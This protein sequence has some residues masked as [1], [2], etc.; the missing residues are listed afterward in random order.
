MNKEV[1]SLFDELYR[2]ISKEK[3]SSE[4]EKFEELK[5]QISVYMG[6]PNAPRG[7]S[8]MVFPLNDGTVVK[9]ALNAAG[10]AQ[11]GMEATIGSDDEVSDIVVPVM[12]KSS[13][14]DYD[15]Y[16][17]IASKRVKPLSDDVAGK[18]WNIFAGYL[19]K[20]ATSSDPINA[21]YPDQTKVDI[22]QAAAE[23]RR[24]EIEDVR[25]KQMSEP[26][27]MFKYLPDSFFESFR[28][29]L[30]RYRGARTG[31]LFKPDSWGID[32][33]SL[34]LIDYGYT[35]RISDDFYTS[36]M[37]A[38]S[39]KAKE[40]FVKRVGERM[41]NIQTTLSDNAETVRNIKTIP[42]MTT[43]ALLLKGIVTGLPKHIETFS[44]GDSL[45]P[46]TQTQAASFAKI[47][48]DNQGKIDRLIGLLPDEDL[49]NK[50]QNEIEDLLLM[51]GS[52]AK[53]KTESI[54]RSII[55]KIL[56]ESMR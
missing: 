9:L 26:S 31:D 4:E 15:G 8:R 37:F 16:L 23:K 13:I 21:Q 6:G 12:G 7:S 32:G 56:K 1:L 24:K 20:A 49:K 45:P 52:L 25:T 14:I 11:N 50:A 48:R 34:K 51:Q 41:K 53:S 18:D 46:L 36:G 28:K 44:I 39:K 17:W 35:R 27:E 22:P 38:G 43:L 55:R 10:F 40:S 29:F 30:S 3:F 5:N 33:N 47:V 19:R 2:E 42:P 54:I